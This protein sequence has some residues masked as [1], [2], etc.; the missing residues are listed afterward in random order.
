MSVCLS[1]LVFCDAPYLLTLMLSSS[2]L[3]DL[4][5]RQG[6]YFEFNYLVINLFHS[7]RW[8]IDVVIG[9]NL[10]YNNIRGALIYRYIIAFFR[11]LSFHNCVTAAF[12]IKIPCLECKVNISQIDKF[13]KIK[14][15]KKYYNN[16]NN[17]VCMWTRL[18]DE[19]NFKLIIYLFFFVYKICTTFY[20]INPA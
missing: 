14:L 11:I 20:S 8:K 4:L 12:I 6:Y 3:V 1:W 17:C 15:L 10:I 2:L 13:D 7:S 18:Y 5:H 16:S 9:P 19:W